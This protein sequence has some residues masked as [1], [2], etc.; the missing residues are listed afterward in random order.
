MTGG[1]RPRATLGRAAVAGRAWFRAR[2]PRG[3]H[4]AH[5]PVRFYRL[6]PDVT[7]PPA[8]GPIGGDLGY[9]KYA[10]FQG[11]NRTLS[12]TFA[13]D[14]QDAELR[15]RLIDPDGFDRAAGALT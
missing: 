10:I 13:L 15:A 3:G 11:D 12:V 2:R 7:P 14:A 8:E 6:H 4:R 5:L 1:G 9:L